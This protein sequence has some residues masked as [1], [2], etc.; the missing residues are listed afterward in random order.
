MSQASPWHPTLKDESLL[1]VITNSWDPACPV[2]VAPSSH[3]SSPVLLPSLLPFF[4]SS[5]CLVFFHFPLENTGSKWLFLLW[6]HF[7]HC[8]PGGRAGSALQ[9]ESPRSTHHPSM[10]C[11]PQSL[12]SKPHPTSWGHSSGPW[13]L[14]QGGVCLPWDGGDKTRVQGASHTGKGD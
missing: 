7:S 4:P 8:T 5:L 13:R 11:G 6:P 3:P 12:S 14:G 2:L 9:Q 1:R 10:P